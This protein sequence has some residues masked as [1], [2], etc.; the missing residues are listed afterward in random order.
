MTS[1]MAMIEGRGELR[2]S[3]DRRWLRERAEISVTVLHFSRSVAPYTGFV[4][5]GL[6]RSEKTGVYLAKR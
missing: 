4:N 2:L 3:R 5:Q 6:L 1:Q